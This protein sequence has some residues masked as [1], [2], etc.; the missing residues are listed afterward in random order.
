M[1]VCARKASARA[2][3]HAAAST[4]ADFP[5]RACAVTLPRAEMLPVTSDCHLSL[6]MANQHSCLALFAVTRG[7]GRDQLHSCTVTSLAAGLLLV[8]HK[9]GLSGPWPSG[10]HCHWQRCCPGP[11][12]G[13]PGSK[14]ASATQ[15]RCQEDSDS[16]SDWWGQVPANLNLNHATQFGFESY[17]N[18]NNDYVGCGASHWQTLAKHLQARQPGQLK[19]QC[20]VVAVGRIASARGAHMEP[21]FTQ[22]HI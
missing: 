12:A 19:C 7:T 22:I 13:C 2:A 4:A 8:G 14:S 3:F 5:A 15:F 18:D 10:S 11:P 20:H 21:W 16:E 17:H 6:V 9:Q 1:C